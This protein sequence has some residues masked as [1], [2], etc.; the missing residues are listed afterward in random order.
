MAAGKRRHKLTIQQ[1]ATSRDALGGQS[2]SWVTVSTP[3]AEALPIRGTNFVNL[4]VAGSDLT[5]KFVLD[6]L[7][8]ASITPAMRVLWNGEQH[9]VVGQ[10]IN[11]NGRNRTIELMCRG[12]VRDS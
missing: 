1:R 6:Y 11:V 2:T 5:I 7:D 8:G 9:E 12:P 4:A 3:W 10:P